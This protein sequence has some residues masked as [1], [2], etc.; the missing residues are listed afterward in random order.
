MLS[1]AAALLALAAA[2]AAGRPPLWDTTLCET[3]LTP[4]GFPHAIARI[5][6]DK[7][8]AVLDKTLLYAERDFSA[9]WS[10]PGA[11]LDGNSRLTGFGAL[12]FALPHGVA[13]PITLTFRVDGREIASRRFAAPSLD[14]V[15]PSEV[16]RP[17]WIG[18]PRP[19]QFQPGVSFE[20][21][22]EALPLLGA[23][24]AELIGTAASGEHIGTLVLPLP[25]WTALA[26]AARPGFADLEARR[27][28]RKCTEPLYI[29]FISERPRGRRR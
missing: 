2:P 12:M 16:R 24:S 15:Y 9:G 10:V 18:A 1:Y 26:Q 28:E 29:N 20:V 6:V 13:Y 4:P 17:E 23:T 11:T 19:N 14:I 7:D 25:D 27:M 22:P 8:H 3:R 21:D 5:H